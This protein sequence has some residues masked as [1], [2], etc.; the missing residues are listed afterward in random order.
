MNDRPWTT[1]D[2]P[3]QTGRTAVITGANSGIGFEVAWGLC[4]R[5]ADLVLACRNG[6]KAAAAAS[7]LAVYCARSLA[8]IEANSAA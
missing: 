1:A 3:D 7:R 2:M 6:Q 8:S 5:G 4:E